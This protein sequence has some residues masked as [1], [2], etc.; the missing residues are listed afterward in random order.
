MK[1]L[2]TAWKALPPQD[3][4]TYAEEARSKRSS[5]TSG[6]TNDQFIL[7]QLKSINNSV[8]SDVAVGVIWTVDIGLG[9]SISVV[10]LLIRVAGVLHSIPSPL[11]FEC[12]LISLFST[13]I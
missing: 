13:K 12:D 4:A 5:T 6:L 2:S 9:T 1:S 7:R 3:K 11:L 8:S 10:K